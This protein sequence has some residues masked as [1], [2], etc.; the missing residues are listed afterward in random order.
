MPRPLY[1]CFPTGSI[2]ALSRVPPGSRLERETCNAPVGATDDMVWKDALTAC[3]N[4]NYAGFTD[5]RL[6]NIRELFSI[7]NHGTGSTPLIGAVQ[8][9]QTANAIYW[10]STSL[11]S[12]PGRAHT[13]DFSNGRIY[14][15]LDGDKTVARFFR[16]V[17]TGP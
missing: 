2:Q 8:F 12:S 7:V 10:T 16:C 11:V 3:E 14:G 1:S 5:W 9:P 15:L 4:L 6:P 13:V 17:R